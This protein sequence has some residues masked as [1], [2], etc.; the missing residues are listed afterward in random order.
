[1]SDGTNKPQLTMQ[2]VS[3]CNSVSS[4]GNAYVIVITTQKSRLISIAPPQKLT[5]MMCNSSGDM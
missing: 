2:T 1:M 3:E 4:K 5:L